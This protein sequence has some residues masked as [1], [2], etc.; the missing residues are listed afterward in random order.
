MSK[1]AANVIPG[2]SDKSILQIMSECALSE[3]DEKELKKYI[4]DKG[5]IFISTPFSRAAA[6]RLINMDVPA[7]KI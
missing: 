2:N 7:F 6:D 1:E 3:R 4:E 5:K